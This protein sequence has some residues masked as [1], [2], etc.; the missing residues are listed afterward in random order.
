MKQSQLVTPQKTFMFGSK[1]T[2][3]KRTLEFLQPAYA[4]NSNKY[5]KATQTE[6]IEAS[7]LE[8]SMTLEDLQLKNYRQSLRV[9]E[10]QGDTGEVEA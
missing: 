9:P 6:R 4:K 7:E 5:H 10:N 2:P 3:E 1:K 8:Q